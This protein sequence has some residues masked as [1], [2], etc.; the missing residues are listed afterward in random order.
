MGH[1]E[2]QN[3]SASQQV[4]FGGGYYRLNPSHLTCFP[5]TTTPILFAYPHPPRTK[6]A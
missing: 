2:V 6:G 5:S 3:S 4:S 1:G